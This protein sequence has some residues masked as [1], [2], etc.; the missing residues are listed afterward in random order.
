MSGITSSVGIFSGINTGQIIEQLMQLEARPKILAQQRI[1]N[2]QTKRAAMLDVN[3]SLLALKNAAGAFRT[4]KVFQATRAT[5]S[6]NDVLAATASTSAQPGSY[7]MTVHRLV[8]TQQQITAGFA[9]RDA[10][11]VGAESFSFLVGGGRLDAETSLSQL[12]GGAGVDRGRI[13]VTDSSGA[14]AT[15]NLSTAVT[16]NDVLDAIN[17]AGGVSVQATVEDGRIRIVDGAGGAGSL[18]VENAFG[19]NTATSL[20]IAGSSATGD[21]IGQRIQYVA[22]STS[23]GSLNDGRGVTVRENVV[24]DFVI[25]SRDGTNHNVR[26]G[27]VFD[28]GDLVQGPAGTLQEVI[29]RINAATNGKVVASINAEG[30]GL[31]LTDTTGATDSDLIVSEASGTGRSTARELGILGSSSDG[32]IQGARLLADINSTLARS[33]NGGS[34]IGSGEF[35]V[36]RRDGSSFNVAV[37]ANDSISDIISR[38]NDAGGGTITASLN[39]AGNGLRIV[40]TT[41]GG[42]LIITDT[43]GTAAADLKIATTGS[44]SGV[45][46]TGNL[47]TRFLSGATRL[48]TL[49][50]NTGVGSGTFRITD[51][52]GDSSEVNVGNS[53]KTID[54]LINLINSR[55]TN[56][57]ARINDAGDGITLEDSSG[58][59]TLA[60]RV[61]DVSGNTARRLN[62]RGTSESGDAGENR[63]VGSFTRTVEFNPGD[64]L[65]KVADKIN[66]AG[67]GVNASVVN[68]GDAVNPFRLILTASNSGVAG[69]VTIDTGGLDLGLNTLARGRDAVVF[70]GSADPANALQL[71]SSTNTLDNVIAGVSIDLKATSAT[72]VELT[73]TRDTNQIETAIQT[74]VESFNKIIDKLRQYDSYDPETNRRGAL[75]GDSAVARIRSEMF[76]MVQGTPKGVDGEFQR[77]FQVGVRIG[78]GSKLT[79]DRERFRSAFEQDPTGVADLFA[80]FEQ[81]TGEPEVLATDDD[82]NPIATTPSSGPVFTRLGMA[83]RFRLLMDS[84]TDTVSGLVTQRSQTFES[85]IELQNRRIR[86]FDVQLERKRQRFEAQFRAME[87]A[88]ASLQSQQSA[89]GSIGFAG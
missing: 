56:I 23:L 26:I 43:T 61:D 2:L 40:D 27:S 34:G 54:D 83:E 28:G 4:N 17:G 24:T 44:A 47:N 59:G 3:T 71:T 73:I 30:T 68:S 55:P 32:E 76:A 11:P 88:I 84:F 78:S 53:I 18:V 87:Q 65:T 7:A 82:G 25:R 64:S 45:V 42:E 9:T 22:G 8:S 39:T 86:N 60:I 16:V 20:G 77:L 89:L 66:A 15:I 41:T 49:N 62:I 85:Q 74:F 36:Q 72:P 48:S 5:S 69:R 75:L 37:T 29:E 67:V 63:V 80:A 10:T 52:S 35:N 12:N 50:G 79:F 6:N 58:N 13:R 70:F 38:I 46:D 19:D 31:T 51:A 33:L 1:V 81:T 21:L 14:V 57:I